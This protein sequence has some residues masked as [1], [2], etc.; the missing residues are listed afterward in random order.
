MNVKSFKSMYKAANSKHCCDN[1][2][3][4]IEIVSKNNICPNNITWD[5][6]APGNIPSVTLRFH[7]SS[8]PD[9]RNVL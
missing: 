8:I 9:S 4:I 5:E 3:V 2:W 6:L 7:P 1:V